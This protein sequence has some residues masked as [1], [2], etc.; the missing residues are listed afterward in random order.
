MEDVGGDVWQKY[1]IVSHLLLA[2]S[3]G[4]I[5]MQTPGFYET[6]NMYLGNKTCLAVL[7]NYAFMLFTVA[8]RVPVILFVGRLAS[9]EAEQLIDVARNYL[10]DAVIF[11]V[12]SK[13]RFEG[14]EIPIDLMVKYLTLL[15]ALKC[16]HVLVYVRLG[17]M[18]QMNIPSYWSILRIC[19]FIYVLAMADLRLLGS[20]WSGLHWKNT[21]IIWLIFEMFGMLL[22]CIFS[23]LRFVVNLM[24]H[25]YEAG[26]SNKTT[27]NFYLELIHDL[28]SLCIFTV[29]TMIF[30]VHNPNNIPA[31]MVID[32]IHV[33]KNLS[34]RIVML[35]HYRNLVSVLETKYPK[36]TQEE[37]EGDDNCII[38]RDAF[39]D[40][41][42]KIE[43][44][45]IFHLSCLKTWLF[46]HSTCPTCRAPIKADDVSDSEDSRVSRFLMNMERKLL[47]AWRWLRNWAIK[48]IEWARKDKS[49]AKEPENLKEFRQNIASAVSTYL[50]RELG[51]TQL[52]SAFA[53]NDTVSQDDVAQPPQDLTIKDS[54]VTPEN[55]DSAAS[56]ED[57]QSNDDDSSSRSLRGRLRNMQPL[58]YM[59]GVVSNAIRRSDS[60][61]SLLDAY[62]DGDTNVNGEDPAAKGLRARLKNIQTFTYM[63]GMVSNAVKRRGST[64]PGGDTNADGGD[65][66]DGDDLTPRG[67]RARMRNMQ[68][69][70]YMKGAVSNAIKRTM[71]TQSM[72]DINADVNAEGE[73]ATPRG[74]REKLRGIQ[75]F[76]YMKERVS[77]AIK[78]KDS[79]GSLE[80]AYR[81]E[82]S[83]ADGEDP[84]S[85]GLR[86]RFK[87]IQPFTY[88]KGVVSN[89]T[90][91]A[92][93]TQSEIDTNADG[94]A[95]QTIQERRRLLNSERL[96][97]KE[98]LKH[99]DKFKR[100]F[101]ISALRRNSNTSQ[102]SE[103]DGSSLVAEVL[104]QQEVMEDV[105][106]EFTQVDDVEQEQV[107]G[108]V[109][110]DLPVPPNVNYVDQTE[111]HEHE[112][113]RK[114][115]SSVEDLELMLLTLSLPGW[116]SESCKNRGD[117]NKKVKAGL[118]KLLKK[119][120]ALKEKLA[121]MSQ[122]EGGNKSNNANTSRQTPGNGDGGDRA[123]SSGGF[124]SEPCRACTLKAD[125]NTAPLTPKDIREIRA[126]KLGGETR[127]VDNMEP[128]VA[129][130]SGGR[131][132]PRGNDLVC[133]CKNVNVSTGNDST[134][135]ST[136]RRQRQQNRDPA[137]IISN[138]SELSQL[139]DSELLSI[140]VQSVSGN[141]ISSFTII[142][143]SFEAQRIA[144]RDFS[145]DP[146]VLSSLSNFPTDE[147]ADA[148]SLLV[149][150][151]QDFEDFSYGDLLLN[152]DET[153]DDVMLSHIGSRDMPEHVQEF[154]IT[155]GKVMR[156]WL[157]LVEGL[158]RSDDR[159]K[160]L[161]TTSRRA[162]LLVPSNTA[163]MDYM[164]DII[165]T[166][167]CAPVNEEGIRQLHNDYMRRSFSYQ[168]AICSLGHRN[169]SV[170]IVEHVVASM[171][172]MDCLI[173]SEMGDILKS[174][175]ADRS[176]SNK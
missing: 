114:P 73:D 128:V 35:M 80:D 116:L 16:F 15:V 131:S 17:N 176:K 30:Y 45:H 105:V 52:V 2:V 158:S 47:R 146:N 120:R 65:T 129:D 12:L 165:S 143:S 68:P 149:K 29:F 36:P 69:L 155:F 86:A 44:G 99:M 3:I 40:T 106:E 125:T 6:V 42:R 10:M 118:L 154:F 64:Q 172:V 26:L 66:V 161:F 59:K 148:I 89:A 85:R 63:K 51:T 37:K 164:R 171:A 9:A 56:N 46:Q 49:T 168:D 142:P 8:C 20:F 115:D 23:A 151:L 95:K 159:F 110:N 32:I 92:G 108:T 11:L 113:A 160:G 41:S 71:S 157:L 126:A 7:Y 5:S 153:S 140:T 121:T 111:P 1:V 75:P 19:T 57:K 135:V 62:R 137:T 117:P 31:Y 43:C 79:S 133:T 104:K 81:D 107:D 119:L 14:S 13:P 28:L 90:R 70:I 102:D 173:R 141:S 88:M 22:L 167:N 27:I 78:R 175:E 112:E 150:E 34:E 55:K 103:S 58:T 123:T 134:S 138:S 97:S 54:L 109:T 162:G 166:I 48:L 101:H 82:E 18:F 25:Y 122:A 61:G 74:L 4:H 156:M 50:N 132:A 170:D 96:K 169:L 87:N 33:I 127:V 98:L 72:G 130:K 147:E 39:D 91:K 38:C 163:H 124:N 136:R 53:V 77:N 84:A 21:F 144:Q 24:D 60:Q 145:N 139:N 83:N 152:S 100:V 93:Y 67:L 76:T 174:V 94:E